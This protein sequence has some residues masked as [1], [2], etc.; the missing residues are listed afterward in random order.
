MHDR[1]NPQPA[2][3]RHDLALGRRPP[4]DDADDL[5]R[6]T[7]LGTDGARD[8][9]AMTS[10][11]IAEA[12]LSLTSY[13]DT[14][15][16]PAMGDLLR[17]ACIHLL[18]V[19]RI[20][21]ECPSTPCWQCGASRVS[22]L[23][24]PGSA[25]EP[26][27]RRHSIG[28]VVV[29]GAIAHDRLMRYAGRFSA[30]LT[31][32]PGLF[33]GKRHRLGR[34]GR[35][36]LSINA[37][38]LTVRRGGIAANICYGLTQ[39]GIRPA[40]VSAVGGDADGLLMGL[41]AN[42]VDARSVL[43]DEQQ[44]TARF[45]C[46]MDEDCTQVATFDEGAGVREAEIDL[47]SV[48]HRTGGAHLVLITSASTDAM[49]RHAGEA[50]AARVP[51]VI[52]PSDRLRQDQLNRSQLREL[53]D[54]AAYLVCN[55][56]Q[57]QLIEETTGWGSVEILR[58]V[59]CLVTT[60]GP[61]GVEIEGGGE[62]LSVPPA[63]AH[64]YVDPIGVRDAFRSG[65]F[66]GRLLGLSLADAARLGCVFSATAADVVGSQEYRA[67]PDDILK[68]IRENYSEEAELAVAGAFAH[69]MR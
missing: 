58:R 37:Q 44:H 32:V 6:G 24:L 54:G 23:D 39:L 8:L 17:S 52:D 59:D 30:Q 16:T 20:A 63:T 51:F 62:R 11:A 46:V 40:I 42:G 61:Q 68:R 69:L 53:L 35:H 21:R 12:V 31:A 7:S 57:R 25:A 64:Y 67:G 34:P 4:S 2:R 48:L 47:S 3:G 5:F 36:I 65:F 49:L 14:P 18:G 66:G 43:I 19:G 10:E 27:G 13:S 1:R 22:Q 41:T 56:F 9:V 29:T 45:D 15:V 50:R 55:S 38:T 33:G 28:G 60:R 26:G